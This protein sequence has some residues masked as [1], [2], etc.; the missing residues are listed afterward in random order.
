M[1]PFIIRNGGFARD[2][3]S[4][5]PIMISR[6][7]YPISELDVVSRSTL[8]DIHESLAALFSRLKPGFQTDIF[9]T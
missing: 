5:G 7:E 6:V 4:S 3:A 8:L 1:M 9:R 2:F